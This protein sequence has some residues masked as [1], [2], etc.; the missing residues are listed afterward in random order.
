MP[1][2]VTFGETMLRLSP[3]GGE[4]IETTDEFRVHVGGSE[5]NVAV[6]ASRLGLDATWLS[7]LPD[8]S[9]GRRVTRG[10]RANGITPVVAWSAEGSQGLYY[11]EPAGTPRDTNAIYDRADAAVTSATPDE[12]ATEH[13]READLFFTTGITPALSATL[14]ET[15]RTLLTTAREAGVT[16]AFDFNYRSK[17]W[18][19]AEAKA[20]LTELF[21][22][23]DWFVI[24]ER[25]AKNILDI[26]ADPED[27][28]ALLS[29]QFAFET[30]IVTRGPAGAVA[31]HDG[32]TYEQ[33][34]FEADTT[35]PIGSGDALVGAFFARRLRGDSVPAALEY[36]AAAAALKRTIPGDMAVIEPRDVDRVLTAQSQEISR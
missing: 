26:A 35:D 21:P 5:S 25:D 9:L 18:P 31:R 11:V 30:V 12:L 19:P 23:V 33:S 28:P 32:E 7:K 20:A 13:I 10:L 36:G 4:R 2:L 1:D 14:A 16:T 27:L 6:A 34:A 22:L 3:D 24:A 8:T 29:E 17:L 15:T